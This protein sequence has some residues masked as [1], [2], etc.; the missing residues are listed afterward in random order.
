M[1]DSVRCL[2]LDLGKV[3]VSLD[4]DHF[5]DAMKRLTGLGPVQLQELFA[6]GDLAS[7]FEC[8]AITGTQFFEE[9]CGLTR[10][11][12]SWDAFLEAWNSIIGPALIPEETIAALARNLR[13]WVISNTNCLHY[14]F[15]ER[16]YPFWQHFEG[17]VL[18]HHVGALKPDSRILF[19]DDQEI[20]VAAAR[21]LGIQ[22][23]QFQNPGQF[24]TE[25][26]SRGLL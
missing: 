17:F 11:R 4:Y 23:F 6:S 12:I 26:K 8:G 9:V 22:A 7:R 1:M 24:A 18:S 14:E 20:N 15:L 2:L 5:A 3:V 25:L 10:A 16:K 19:V 21:E 13:L